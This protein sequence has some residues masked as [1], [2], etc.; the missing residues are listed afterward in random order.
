MET[1]KYLVYYLL[2]LGSWLLFCLLHFQY[3]HLSLSSFAAAPRPAALVVLPI[4]LDASFLPSPTVEADNKRHSA[5]SSVVARAASPSPS[6]PPLCE[7]RYVYMLDVPS[8]FDMLRDCVAG[9]PLFDDMWS[10]CAI[11][12][13]AGL[14]PKIGPA[15]GN[16]SDGDTDIIPSTGW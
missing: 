6:S 7:E 1:P 5:S 4:A 8:R 3:F 12:V 15:T 11:T 9:S 13:N 2:I 10:W 14:G 16:G